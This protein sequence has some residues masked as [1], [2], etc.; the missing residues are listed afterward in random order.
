MRQMRTGDR[1]KFVRL[2]NKRVNSALKQM[3]LIAN[4]SN[5][6]NYDYTEADVEQIFKALQAGLGDAKKR[7]Q[8]AGSGREDGEFSLK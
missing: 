2:A 3:K 8:T 4:L 5:K 6:S 7:F 1:D